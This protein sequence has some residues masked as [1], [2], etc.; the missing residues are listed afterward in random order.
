MVTHRANRPWVATK[1]T[2]LGVS[3]M[4]LDHSSQPFIGQYERDYASIFMSIESMY[5]QVHFEEVL[6]HLRL[7]SL[8]SVY[9][10]PGRS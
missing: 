3:L 1:A 6:F 10:V 9:T 8:G 7:V 5:S 2:Q 4:A